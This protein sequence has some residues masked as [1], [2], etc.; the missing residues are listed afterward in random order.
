MYHYLRTKGRKT[1]V[2]V[3]PW[4]NDK[5][6][7]FTGGVCNM[8][9]LLEFYDNLDDEIKEDFRKDFGDIDEM[10]GWFFEKFLPLDLNYVVS[11]ENLQNTHNTIK[12]YLMHV[13]EKYGLEYGCD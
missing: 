5:H 9:Y 11:Y 8:K 6:Y 4:I 2:D 1:I 10:R 7:E 13:G 12:N 3:E